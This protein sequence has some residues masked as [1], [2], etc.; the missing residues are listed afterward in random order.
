MGPAGKTA[1]V[2]ILALGAITGIVM[3]YLFEAFSMPKPGIIGS[4]DRSNLTEIPSREGSSNIMDEDNATTG[5][6]TEGG[7]AATPAEQ[8]TTTGA[9]AAAT[10]T[11]PMGAA[12]PGN[13]AYEP[14]SL[15]V[16][17]GDAIDVV[18]E[19]SSPHTV[20]SGTGLE[21]PNAGQMFDTSIITPAASGQLATTDLEA[22]EYDYH[23]TVHPFM[24]GKLIVQ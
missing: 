8:T 12:T 6:T 24:T 19:D 13:P 2:A 21:D 5:T 7:G 20:T 9:T 17:K 23:C 1:F 18:N 3:Y 4:V 16:K 11:I 10:L 22:G 14:A 15:T